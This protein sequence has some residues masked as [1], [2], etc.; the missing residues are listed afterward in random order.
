[1]KYYAGEIAALVGLKNTTTGDT[2]CD[3]DKAD[4]F[5]KDHVPEPVIGLRIEPKTKADQ[6]KMGTL[7]CTAWP[8]KIRPSAFPAMPKRARRSF[9]AWANFTWKYC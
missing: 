3:P 4:H 6:E 1:M 5:G 7:L 2:L 9:P 8:K